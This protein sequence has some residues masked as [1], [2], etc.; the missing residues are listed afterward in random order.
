M[1]S[2]IHDAAAAW[3]S[4]ECVIGDIREELGMAEQFCNNYKDASPQSH[5]EAQNLAEAFKCYTDEMAKCCE[6]RLDELDEVAAALGKR[7]LY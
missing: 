3:Q 6:E 5:L 2:E 7:S 4:C 1:K